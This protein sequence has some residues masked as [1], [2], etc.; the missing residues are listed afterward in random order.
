M[1]SVATLPA[2][3]RIGRNRLGTS[4]I[5]MV[6]GTAVGLWAVHI[7]LIGA[8]QRIDE[9]LL[10]MMLLTVAAGAIAAMPVAGWL[11]GRYGADRTTLGFAASFVLVM[12]LPV[13][14]PGLPS[15]FA[16]ALLFGIC[17][18]G[19]DV[20]MNAQA[21]DVERVRARPTMSSF[22]G[23]WSLGGLA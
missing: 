19:L 14:A 10:G 15:L 18:G 23:F 2:E 8:A 9:F 16:A 12:S 4:A 11:A 20:A 6:N 5:F 17:N 7:P 1:S 3:E 13:L 22:H 21:T